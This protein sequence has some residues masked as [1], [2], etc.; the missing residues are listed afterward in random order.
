M[1]T[2]AALFLFILAPLF[3][4]AGCPILAI[5]SV[6][7]VGKHEPPGA[8]APSAGC[9]RSEPPASGLCNRK[10]RQP[11]LQEQ[12]FIR[13]PKKRRHR[14]QPRPGPGARPRRQIPLKLPANPPKPVLQKISPRR[15]EWR[16]NG[17]RPA[18]LLPAH[19]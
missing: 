1:R 13:A 2:T 8:Q 16:Q 17:A 9:L 12:T 10:N 4:V 18:R 5:F 14:V 3:S 15:V 7:R 11:S 19:P 6:A